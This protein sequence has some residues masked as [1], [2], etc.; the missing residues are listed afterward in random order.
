MKDKCILL[1][2]NKRLKKQY[3]TPASATITGNRPK[4]L[5]AIKIWRKIENLWFMGQDC[6]PWMD[7]KRTRA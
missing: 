2:V 7:R 3:K 1:G 4:S 6:F 5:P